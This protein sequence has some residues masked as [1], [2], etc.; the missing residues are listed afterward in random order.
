MGKGIRY[1]NNDLKYVSLTKH[2]CPHC[3]NTLKTVKVSK[4]VN[5]DSHEA[6][7]FDFDFDVLVANEAKFVWKEFECPK[8]RAHFAVD[9]LKKLEGVYVE[10][11]K[12][13]EKTKKK[14]NLINFIIFVVIGTLILLAISFIKHIL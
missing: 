9:E 10:P 5:R 3:A 2:K 6:K 8:C 4:V 7:D 13:D 14:R 11:L 12:V 1:F